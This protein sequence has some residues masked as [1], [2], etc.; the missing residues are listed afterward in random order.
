[1]TLTS[2]H[3]ELSSQSEALGRGLG[4]PPAGPGLPLPGASAPPPWPALLLFW[5]R[6]G[7][8]PDGQ[9][10]QHCDH[11]ESGQG[12]VARPAL[13]PCV[14]RAWLVHEP[15]IA[16]AWGQGLAEQGGQHCGH[17]PIMPAAFLAGKGWPSRGPCMSLQPQMC[18]AV[19][20]IPS[21][22][23]MPNTHLVQKMCRR[24]W[25]WSV[26]CAWAQSRCRCHQPPT[27]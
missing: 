12:R 27:V 26:V 7:Q 22:Q 5:A 23:S 24:C 14:V 9:Q 2:W 17:A 15:S 11:V 10:G 18:P 13:Q 6:K 8:D 1:M 16:A 25:F 21:K 4:E 20:P 3:C 19:W